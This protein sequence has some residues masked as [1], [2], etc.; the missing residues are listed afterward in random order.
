MK[1]LIAGVV[2]GA[3]I[4]GG[5]WFFAGT[6]QAVAVVGSDKITAKDFHAKLEQAQGKDVLKKMIDDKVILDQAKQ[7]KLQVT[8]KEVDDELANFIKER[9][10]G[11]KTQFQS[12]LKQYNMTEDDIKSDI[13]SSLTAKKIATKDVTISDQEIKDYYD[14]N[15]ES[16]GTPEQVHARHILVKDEAKAKELYEKLKA[17]PADFE[18]LAKEN[19]EDP[20]SK[21]KG[22]D[23]GTF[24][25]GAMV[26]EFETAAF[27]AKPNEI[28]GPVKSEFGYHIIQVLEHKDAK[29]PTLEESKDKITQTLKDQKATPYTDLMKELYTK[30]KITINRSEYKDI[31]NPAVVDPTGGAT[32]GTTTPA[33]G[34]D[35]TTPST[36]AK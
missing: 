13:R 7:L 16:L 27:A 1:Q 12:A 2:A 22:G 25:K 4:V 23:L 29:I 9:F 8:D 18:K 34:G 17:N 24:G 21:D 14:K 20:G 36:P 19:S 31:L 3:V 10:S 5:V 30:E 11:D 28:V 35:A 26:P 33:T 32:G 15:K 6:E